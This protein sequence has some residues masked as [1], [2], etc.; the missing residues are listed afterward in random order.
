MLRCLPDLDQPEFQ[1]GY[2][3]NRD[4][5]RGLMR[6]LYRGYPV[7]RLLTWE[8]QADR[9]LVR[10]GPWRPRPSGCDASERPVWITSRNG[11]HRERRRES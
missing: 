2:V 10:G 1:R 3:W 4:Q 7:G 9:S 8:T 6:S 5:I 11:H